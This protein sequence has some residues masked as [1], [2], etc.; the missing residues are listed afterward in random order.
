MLSVKSMPT[1]KRV[2]VKARRK[3]LVVALALALLSLACGCGKST[4]AGGRYSGRV[5]VSGSTTL[6]PLIQEASI[7]FMDANPRTKVDVQGGG[8]SV[9]TV[10]YT[11]LTLPTIY[12]V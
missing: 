10:S 12:S 3:A 8:S 6:L 5:R 2:P 9:G 7:E 4:S 11:H 1:M